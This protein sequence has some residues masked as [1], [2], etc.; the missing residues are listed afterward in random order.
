M[1]IHPGVSVRLNVGCGRHVLD[2]WTNVDVQRSPRAKRDPEIFSDARS[3]PLPDECADELMAIHVFEHFYRWEAEDV[4]AEWR[5]L[6]KPSGKLILEL[7][8]LEKCCRNVIDG[9][10]K[11]GKDQDQLGMW[12]LYGDPRERDPY[13]IHRWAWTPR[14]LGDLLA[15]NGFRAIKERPTEWH[16][17]GRAHRDMRIEAIKQ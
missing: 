10:M 4:L 3:I 11:G 1:A 6:L 15:A 13:M 5:R 2:G 12:G 8:D 7:P 17:A 14:T 9:G 16:P